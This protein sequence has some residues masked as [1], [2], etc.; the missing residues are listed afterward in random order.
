MTFTGQKDDSR[1]RCGQQLSRLWAL[2]LSRDDKGRSPQVTCEMR[3]AAN[4]II[5]EVEAMSRAMLERDR[6]NPGAETFLWVRVTRLAMTADQAV[7]AARTGDSAAL[8]AH[9]RRLEALTVA[10]WTVRDAI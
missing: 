1:L 8:R 5:G 6:C 4:A 2:A 10:I 3:D 7:E 9:L